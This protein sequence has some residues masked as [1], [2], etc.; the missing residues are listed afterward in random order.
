[1]N[2]PDRMVRVNELLKRELGDLIE[3][4]KFDGGIISVTKVDTAPNL[5]N[6]VVYVSI[7]DSIYEDADK[8]L[9]RYMLKHRKYMQRKI[10]QDLALKHTPVLKFVIDKTISGGDDVLELLNNLD[11]LDSV[12]IP[13][14]PGVGQ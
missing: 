10:S 5:R 1:M 2:A 8:M 9:I 14:I 7:F 6:A 3:R 11:N 4:D 13:E 12:D